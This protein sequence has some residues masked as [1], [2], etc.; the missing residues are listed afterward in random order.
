MLP[1]SAKFISDPLDCAACPIQQELLRLL[2]N[3]KSDSLVCNPYLDLYKLEN[4]KKYLDLLRVQNPPILLVGEAPGHRGCKL[5]GIPFTSPHL[6]QTS[7]H[8]VMQSLR[9]EVIL[10]TTESEQSARVVYDYLINQRLGAVLWNA[11]P[12]HPHQKG[13]PDSNRKPLGKELKEGQ[14]FLK[15]IVEIFK[16]GV[17]IGVGRLGET[18]LRE[19]ISKQ[20]VH[21]VRHPSRGGKVNFM[22]GMNKIFRAQSLIP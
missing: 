5:T 17:F 15:L 2:A 22:K 3:R 8:P 4:L 13:N 12:F 7:A 11:F 21:Y 10:R 20:E 14:R 18:S 16:P 19:T 9:S 6:I 1:R